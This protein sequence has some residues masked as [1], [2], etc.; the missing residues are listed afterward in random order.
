MKKKLI[1]AIKAKFVGIDDNTAK[2]LAERAIAKN[3][4]ITNDDEVAAAV[5]AITLSDVLKSVN[6]FSADEAVK[7]YE[8]KYN[9]EK[10][11]KKSNPDDEPNKDKGKDGDKGADKGAD[12]DDKDKPKDNP[13]ESFK[14]LLD[15][16]KKSMAGEFEA[17]KND[18]SA[19]KSGKISENR[20]AKLEEAIKNLKDTQ[21]K[22][23]GRIDLSK[24]SEDEFESFMTEVK[25]EVNDIIAENRASGSSVTPPFG[26]RHQESGRS[27]GTKE[28]SKEE[29]D[30]L[31]GKFGLQQNDKS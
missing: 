31:V 18:L 28:A 16:F 17:I 14:A 26:G 21:K 5:E 25:E 1:E 15:E 23:Y 6:D 22:P 4:A 2:R 27:S 29:L 19:M 7:R 12:G 3:E 20:K 11:V 10:G 9:L 30:E 13:A 24:M 8:E